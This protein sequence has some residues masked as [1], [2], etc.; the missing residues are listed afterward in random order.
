MKKILSTLILF[1]LVLAPQT[2]SLAMTYELEIPENAEFIPISSINFTDLFEENPVK[3]EGIERELGEFYDE[4]GGGNIITHSRTIGDMAYKL[5]HKTSWNSDK[6]AS[7][8]LSES[9]YW[10][11]RQYFGYDFKWKGIPFVI[12]GLYDPESNILY[13]FDSDYLIKKTYADGTVDMVECEQLSFGV[14]AKT[15]VSDVTAKLKK[16]PYVTVTYNGEMIIFDQKPVI[17]NG[18]TLVPLRAIFEKL[19]ATI[20]WNGETGTVTAKKDDTTIS[21]TIDNTTA[22]KNNDT[23]TLD[24]PAKIINGRTLVPVR[25]IADCFGVNVDWNAEARRVILTQ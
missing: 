11:I 24:V 19:G 25:F 5:F 23:I 20:E 7:G 3:Q 16:F 22:T 13:H 17:E 14:N 2:T 10:E 9:G 12:G 6:V 21:L 15:I 4:S 1:I 8:F 18:R